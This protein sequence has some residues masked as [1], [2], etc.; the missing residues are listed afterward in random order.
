MFCSL[1]RTLAYPQPELPMQSSWIG[2]GIHDDAIS[3]AMA[4]INIRT[5]EQ[6]PAFGALARM[7]KAYPQAE[8]NRRSGLERAVS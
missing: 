3:A 8:S 5:G 2:A 7:A 6:R 4:A 1:T